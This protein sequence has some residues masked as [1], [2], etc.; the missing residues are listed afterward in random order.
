MKDYQDWNDEQLENS[1]ANL[2]FLLKFAALSE[3]A[4]RDFT[5]EL[6]TMREELSNRKSSRI[7]N[8]IWK[9]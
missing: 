9:E 1:I 6:E 5:Q 7:S 4:R 2:N 3:K 8:P